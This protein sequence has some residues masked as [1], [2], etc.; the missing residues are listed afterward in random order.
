MR[1][2]LGRSTKKKLTNV[3]PWFFLEKL[4]DITIVLYCSRIFHKPTVFR[5]SNISDAA[6]NKQW[7]EERT[8]LNSALFTIASIAK[9]NILKS[10]R[11]LH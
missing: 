2:D 5:S 11:L 1:D 6:N 10:W 4:L 9:R 8:K 7:L 3:S